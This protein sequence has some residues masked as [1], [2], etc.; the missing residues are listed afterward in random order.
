MKRRHISEITEALKAY[1]KLFLVFKCLQQQ[2]TA[3]IGR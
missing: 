2:Q 3:I 1:L